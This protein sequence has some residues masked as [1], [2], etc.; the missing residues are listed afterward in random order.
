M[1]VVKEQKNDEE[2]DEGEIKMKILYINK[3]LRK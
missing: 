2:I 1:Q 3:S